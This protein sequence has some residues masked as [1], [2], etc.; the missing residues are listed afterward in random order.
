MAEDLAHALQRLADESRPIAAASLTALSDMPRRQAETFRAAW[1]SLSPR[2]RLDLVRAL[3]EGAEANIHLNFYAILR[4]VLHDP[5]SQVRTLAINGLWEDDRPS[6][7]EPLAVLASNDP[8]PEVRAAAALSLGRF[9]L[10]GALGDIAEGPAE[11]AEQALR[12]AWQRAGEPAEV[13][14]RALEGLAYADAG[15][16]RELIHLAYYDDDILLR[17]SAVLAMGRTADR[18]WARFV[19]EELASAEPAMRRAA[20]VAAGELALAPAVPSLIRALNDPDAEVRQAA[21]VAL[22][23]IGGPAA[24]RALQQAERDP[25]PAQARAAGEALQVLD[26]NSGGV[27]DSL[28]DLNVRHADAAEPEDGGTGDAA[29]GEIYDYDEGE[30]DWLDDE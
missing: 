3:V 28:F 9:V 22:G 2:R 27:S 21:T 6:L 5:D 29:D 4:E 25:D 24:R 18:Y 26:F 23:E 30:I 12:S 7:V 1:A 8:V 17:Q 20:A 19:L 16:L 15:D 11:R 10:L 14:R 13:R